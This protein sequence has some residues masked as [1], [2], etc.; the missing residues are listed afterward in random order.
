MSLRAI[1]PGSKRFDFGGGGGDKKNEYLMIGVLGL[2]IAL[3]LTFTIGRFV[4]CGKGGA[5]G[6]RK[7]MWQCTVCGHQFEQEIDPMETPEMMDMGVPAIDCPVCAEQGKKS[8]ALSMTQC[9]NCEKYYLSDRTKFMYE[10]PL[11]VGDERPPADIC[12][13]CGTDRGK[14]IREHRKD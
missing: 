11:F 8:P 6:D 1:S 3:A 2:I 12:P 7:A 4:G 10:N 14:W 5:A 13:H 9:P